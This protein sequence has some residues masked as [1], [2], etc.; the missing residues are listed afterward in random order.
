MSIK[1]AVVVSHPAGGGSLIA[2][3]LMAM[4]FKTPGI[5]SDETNDWNLVAVNQIMCDRAH[6]P[7]IS[8]GMAKH[9]MEPM[10]GYIDDKIKEGQNWIMHDPMLHDIFRVRAA[11]EGKG[12]RL[13]NNNSPA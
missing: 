9:A 1:C 5:P 3:T 2:K 6:K 12:S 13:Q 4:G 7:K 10:T 11:A 8:L